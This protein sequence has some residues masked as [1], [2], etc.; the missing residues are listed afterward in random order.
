[1]PHLK[2]SVTELCPKPDKSSPCPLPFFFNSLQSYFPCTLR[3]PNDLFP[4]GASIKSVYWTLNNAWTF[5]HGLVYVSF[6]IFFILVLNLADGLR[7][8]G[9]I[10]PLLCC[11]WRSEILT[12]SVDW[13]QLSRFLPVDGDRIQSP[14]RHFKEKKRGRWIT[15]QNF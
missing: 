11:C 8:G 15:S 3:Y 6:L 9:F 5:M 12:S 1:M 7:C 2:E 13:A 10:Y 14:K 4:F